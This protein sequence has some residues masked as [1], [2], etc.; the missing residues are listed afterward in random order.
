MTSIP[1]EPM[2]GAAQAFADTSERRTAFQAA[3]GLH[4]AGKLREAE[5]AYRRILEAWPGDPD[6]LHFLGTIALQA[7]RP[8]EAI[9][10]I[11]KAIA[12]RPKAAY[13]YN[14]GL[15]CIAARDGA[16]AEAAFRGALALDPR[17][18]EAQF[19]LGSLLLRRDD[20]PAAIEAYR[21][22][23][24]T[25]PDFVDALTNLGNVLVGTGRAVEAIPLLER[26]RDLRPD[27]ADVLTNLGIA[28]ATMS[29]EAALET[30]RRALAVSPDHF[31][32]LYNVGVIYS[33]L[34]QPAEAAD[35]LQRA[36]AVAPRRVE[37]RLS[38]ASELT[39]L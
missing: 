22:A 29:L 9:D 31:G 18:A 4:K 30:Y 1:T 6:A 17:H 15:A 8:A 10:A 26:A 24:A 2:A 32:A 25:R 12:V 21:G 34:E 36:V 20:V 5:G 35:F 39:D 28:Q 14:L 3:L 7:R 33:K 38:L 11:R 37:A 27:D 23:I 19:H 13:H 16:G